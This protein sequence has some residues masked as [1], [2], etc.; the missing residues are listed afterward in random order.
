[1]EYNR[2]ILCILLVMPVFHSAIVFSLPFLTQKSECSTTQAS[3]IPIVENGMQPSIVVKIFS[4][5]CHA[6]WIRAGDQ[7]L[8]TI[9]LM[10]NRRRLQTP[11]C[12][13]ACVENK[14]HSLHHHC[15]RTGSLVCWIH[16][17]FILVL[18]LSPICFSATRFLINKEGKQPLS[19]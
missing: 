18:E 19:R 5:K 17:M 14:C 11:H 8:W 12:K 9:L 3:Q 4:L 1:M 16:I 15:K 13:Y 6:Q 7:G 10:S 2:A